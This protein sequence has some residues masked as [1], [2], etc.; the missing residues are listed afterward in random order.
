MRDGFRDIVSG[1]M[2]IDDFDDLSDR[3]ERLAEWSKDNFPLE[4]DEHA[5]VEMMIQSQ[6]ARG[7]ARGDFD[8]LG[9]DR[10]TLINALF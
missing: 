10:E 9:V 3:I 2:T 1:W 5:T 8:D 6:I 7:I 4:P